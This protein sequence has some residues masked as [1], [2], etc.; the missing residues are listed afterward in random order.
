VNGVPPETKLLVILK[1][2]TSGMRALQRL[3]RRSLAAEQLP[4][5]TRRRG[6]M[7]RATDRLLSAGGA[8]RRAGSVL[9]EAAAHCWVSWRG[10]RITDTRYRVG[11]VSLPMAWGLLR[12]SSC[13]A[14]SLVLFSGCALIEHGKTQV[15]HIE[16][17]PPG[18]RA[19]IQP[20]NQ[21]ITTPGDVVLPR[22]SSY[23]VRIERDGYEH[24]SVALVSTSSGTLWHTS[25]GYSRPP[26]SLAL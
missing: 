10:P 22:K 6:Q 23:A 25:S 4:R 8:P 11:S 9:A 2:P 17:S 3:D 18:A 19:I 7:Y 13:L 26:G 14:T 24:A 21:E 12:I 1:S 20:G 16:S 5:R 15:V